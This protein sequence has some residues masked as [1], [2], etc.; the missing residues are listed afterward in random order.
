MIREQKRKI[1]LLA[2][3][4]DLVT[5]ID[6]IDCGADA[7]Y[8]GAGKF[9]ARHSATN[10]IED[11]ARVAEY[12]HLYGVKVY[13]TLN[14][15]LFDDELEE[16]REQAL[17]LIKA[18]VD[19]LIVQDMAYW[20]MNL[21]I[22]LHASTQTNCVTPEKVK[23]LEDMGFARAIL[24][25]SLSKNEI[26]EIRRA[27][28]IELEAF[29]HGA[30]CVS[31]SGRCFFSRSTSER[32]GNRGECSQPCRLEYD[33]CNDKGEIIIKSK[34]LL[35]VRDLDLSAR[36]GEMLDLG[37]SSFKIEGRLKDRTYVRNIVSLYRRLLD[38]E[39]AKRDDV[40]RSSVGRSAIE[41]EPNASRTF[42]R[43]AGEYLFD[44]K[45]RGVASFDTPKAMGERVGKI[46]RVDRRGVVLDCKHDL[47]TGDGV[48]FISNG[49]LVGTN[50]VGIEGERIQLNRYDG[51]AVE[52][53]LFRNYNRLF[54]QAV[55]RSRVKRTISV[56]LR[57]IFREDCI[58]LVAI[59]ETGIEQT[60]SV[61]Y[62]SEEVR[63]K[64]KG[65]EALRR[66]LSR[67]GDTMFEVRNIEIENIRFAP[68]SVVAGLRREALEKLEMGRLADYQFELHSA[69]YIDSTNRRERRAQYP[70]KIL[71][72]QD[73]V[74]NHL[75]REFYTACGVEEIAEGLDCRATTEGEQVVI[76]DYC[77]RREIG[78]CLKE[79]PRL[80]GEL[81]LERGTKKYRLCFDCKACQMRLIDVSHE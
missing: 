76:S 51:V 79:R 46:L 29:V 3:A 61:E 21:P 41:F 43:G 60:V 13:A 53:E 42:T 38:K 24:E 65:E 57:L 54:S 12:A 67:S 23:F 74:T 81:Y 5:A 68:M 39:I 9:G 28:H 34:H 35:S 14:T 17:A 63:D 66:Q 7:V 64:A 26:A 30:I 36:L 56:D 69:S 25:R 40:E 22:P 75:A 15:L 55:E 16:A 62:A 72:P 10:P 33:L 59:D 49:A 31:Q 78:E 48:C 47:A 19:A 8:I 45:R 32:S 18:G 27:T 11:I 4:K 80:K 71:T 77:I 50:V 70:S 44:G 6:A 52:V 58:E 1:E 37:I 20:Q 2:P 73:N